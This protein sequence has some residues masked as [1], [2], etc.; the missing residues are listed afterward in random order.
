MKKSKEVESVERM[1]KQC[2]EMRQRLGISKRGETLYQSPLSM[3]SES[4]VV[5]EADG[6][7]GATLQVV[8]GNYPDDYVTKSEQRFLSEDVACDAAEA[9]VAKHTR[10]PRGVV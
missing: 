3:W 8:V 10:V 9:L 7:G 1:E 2:E 4:D 5:V 6:R